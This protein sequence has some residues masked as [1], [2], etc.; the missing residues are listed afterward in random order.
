MRHTNTVVAFVYSQEEWPTS[1]HIGTW[2]G[3]QAS[4][5]DR[6]ERWIMRHRC[7]AV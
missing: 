3:S 1:H 5:T 4:L 7:R 6:L 2:V